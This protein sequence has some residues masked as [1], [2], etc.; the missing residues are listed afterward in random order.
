MSKNNLF[1]E[2]RL[3]I[4]Y[5]ELIKQ[6]K[7]LV[8]DISTEFSISKTTAR[9]DL[10][11]LENRGLLTRTHGGAILKETKAELSNEI[12]RDNIPFKKRIEEHFEE[13]KAISKLAATLIK[14]G[15]TLMIDGGSTTCAI[16]EFLQ[17]KK[18]LTII[19]NSYTLV[20]LV[21]S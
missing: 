20:P 15:D 13:K 1:Q 6:K 8:N 18:N 7:V 10:I 4:I 3:R 21:S 9:N 2:E 19:T 11:E 16:A 17:E 14:N 12:M 5:Q